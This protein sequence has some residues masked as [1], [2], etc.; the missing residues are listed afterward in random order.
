MEEIVNILNIKPIEWEALEHHLVYDHPQAVNISLC[1]EGIFQ[2]ELRSG[3]SRWANLAQAQPFPN[4][5]NH[6]AHAEIAN[7]VYVA[8][9]SV[10]D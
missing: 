7:F 5:F 3:V 10:L 4:I 2:E 1:W 9:W 6:S 8:I